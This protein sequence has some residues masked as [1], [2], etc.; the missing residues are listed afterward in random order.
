MR[1][2]VI[3]YKRH[4]MQE[5][6]AL[7]PLVH[8]SL[9]SRPEVADAIRHMRDNPAV[10]GMAITLGDEQY[11]LFSTTRD[12]LAPNGFEFKPDDDTLSKEEISN[13]VEFVIESDEKL[14]S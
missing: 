11:Q 1:Q 9:Y 5:P 3:L 7:M 8:A 13:L 10:S 12:Q 2:Y 14:A 4:G 6:T